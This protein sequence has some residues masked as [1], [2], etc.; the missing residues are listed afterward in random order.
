VL[1]EAG[2]RRSIPAAVGPVLAC[3]LGAIAVAGAVIVAHSS[4]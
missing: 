3:A 2:K 1:N 4:T